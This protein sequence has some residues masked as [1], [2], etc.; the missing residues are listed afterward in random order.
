M[1]ERANNGGPRKT[2]VT[3]RSGVWRFAFTIAAS[4]LLFGSPAG[5]KSQ[6]TGDFMITFGGERLTPK[7]R[8][9][10]VL[11][12][13]NP[14]AE[15]FFVHVPASYSSH[16]EYGLIVFTD[17][18]EEVDRVPDGWTK[19]L[20]E[21]KLLFVAA[22]NAGNDQDTNR[23]LG[24][25]VLGA[26]E[27]M[28][29]YG[30]DPN[31]VYAAGFSGGARMSGLLG[32]FQPDVFHGT[33]QNCGAD[34]YMRVP[35]VYATSWVSTTGQPYGHFDATT[36]EIARAKRVRFVLIT[37]TNDFRRGNIL[38]IYNGGFAKQHFAAKLI[39][40]PGMDHEIC[41]AATLSAAL[42]FIESGT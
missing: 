6:R 42:D 31:R 2:T 27:M 26:L 25:A 33:I 37:G 41:N 39:D 32:F 7:N 40:V 16:A 23:R 30:I 19:A 35:T 8:N 24:L 20:D 22:E 9:A 11:Y 13:L 1:T 15:K 28:R 34:F 17:A 10:K 12:D 36:D 3:C 18:A 29:R 5:A 14:G 38:D 4:T 21:R